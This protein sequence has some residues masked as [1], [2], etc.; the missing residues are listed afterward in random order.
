M[1]YQTFSAALAQAHCRMTQHP[2]Q[3]KI[4]VLISAQDCLGNLELS[5]ARA[6]VCLH[7]AGL[8]TFAGV[9]LDGLLECSY[10]AESAKEQDHFILFVP[11]RSDLHK[12]PHRCP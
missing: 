2:M 6:R 8:R 10:V 4:E 3:T 12:K 9:V 1:L 5:V 11:D 7:R